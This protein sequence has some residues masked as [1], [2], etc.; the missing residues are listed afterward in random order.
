MRSVEDILF[1][2]LW[3]GSGLLS[4]LILVYALKHI[5]KLYNKTE[6]KKRFFVGILV[7]FLAGILG[8]V[9]FM[10][11]VI[12]APMYD[13][14]LDVSIVVRYLVGYLGFFLSSVFCAHFLHILFKKYLP[15]L[16][17]WYSS[18]V[19]FSIIGLHPIV[20]YWIERIIGAV[21]WAISSLTPL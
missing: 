7:G 13:K 15:T 10:M 6:A 21:K 20:Y 18:L 1:A 19:A 5:V 11:F 4:L 2:I 16:P 12:F 14:L 3:H 8:I 9:L 17:M